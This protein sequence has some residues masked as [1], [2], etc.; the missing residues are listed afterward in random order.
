MRAGATH[1]RKEGDNEQRAVAWK[2]GDDRSLWGW[3][4]PSWWTDD[5]SS[6]EEA[7]SEEEHEALRDW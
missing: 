3:R 1:L 5:R 7:V 2:E 4:Q 6:W